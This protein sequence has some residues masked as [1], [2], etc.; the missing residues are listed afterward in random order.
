MISL[1]IKDNKA[2]VEGYVNVV[3]RDSD[4]LSE[5]GKR[6]IERIMQ[7]AFARSLRRSKT[8]KVLLNHD[9]SHEIASTESG[10]AELREDAVGLWCRAVITDE[11]TVKKAKEGKLR[12]WS[13]GFVP[14]EQHETEE[15]GILH[16][17]VKNLILREV[18]ILDDRKVPAYPANLIMTRDLEDGQTMQIRMVEDE[19]IE[20]N[21]DP[22]GVADTSDKDE[23]GDP[24]NRNYL[25]RNRLMR[26][27]I[28]K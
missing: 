21:A 12:G 8:V 27:R 19:I 13:F 11:E 9:N 2:T 23:A 6:F 22:G 4:I 16:R 18:S 3:E 24:A 7:G 17:A 5:G 25:F 14:L 26:A 15:D 28:R 1:R 20:E 10:T